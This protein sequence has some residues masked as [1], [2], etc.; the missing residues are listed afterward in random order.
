MKLGV[1][2]GESAL[3]AVPL[4]AADPRRLRPVVGDRRWAQVERALERMGRLMAGRRLVNINSTAT[5]GGVAELLSWMLPLAIGGGVDARWL[6]LSAPAEFF[7]LTK[8]LHNMLHEHSQPGLG[9]ADRE[10]YEAALGDAARG[11]ACLVRPGDVAVVHDPQPAGLIPALKELGTKVIW[12]CHVGTDS[13]GP[14]AAAARRFLLP[15]VGRADLLVYSRRQFAWNELEAQPSTIIH[16]TINPLSPKNQPLEPEQVRAALVA[17]GLFEGRAGPATF[18]RTDGRTGRIRA[19]ARIRQEQRLPAGAPYVAQV[20]RWD[21]LKDPVGVLEGFAGHVPAAA[22]AHLVL[23]GPAPASVKDDPESVQVLR[24]VGW[25][26]RRLPAEV[27]ARIHVVCL[28]M[29]DSEENAAMVNAVQRGAAV[30]VQKSLEEAF[31]LTVAEAMWKARPVVASRRGGIQ[32]QIEDGRNGLL[33]DD[34]NDLAA[35]GAAVTRLLGDPELARRLG[36]A[37]RE[38]VRRSFLP[39]SALASWLAAL[40]GLLE[41]RD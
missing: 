40:E 14:I 36:G 28:P 19:R 22:G 16:P 29:E 26:W 12:R 17:V 7:G 2:R 31:G 4:R 33:L 23:A 32:E 35:F 20:S 25:R 34:P 41:P 39:P 38:T 15:Y 21:R 5:G 3:Q 8:R 24:E 1:E 18:E 13:A 37:A 30:V 9:P 11:L 6:V 27:R 10:L